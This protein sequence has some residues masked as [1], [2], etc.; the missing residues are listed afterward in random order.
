M[1]LENILAQALEAVASASEIAQLEEI[2][3]KAMEE[4]SAKDATHASELETL[5][6]QHTS[7]VDALKE[8]MEEERKAHEATLQV[9]FSH[10]F[11]PSLTYI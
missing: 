4:H 7:E 1:N 2:R 10:G 5:R 9:H 8:S 3:V 6:S 11:E